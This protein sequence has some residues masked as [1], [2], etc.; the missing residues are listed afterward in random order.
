MAKYVIPTYYDGRPVDKIYTPELK[1]VPIMYQT[2]DSQLICSNCVN[3]N[4]ALCHD[5][6]SPE[7]YV[8]GHCQTDEATMC[9]ECERRSHDQQN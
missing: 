3:D 1:A 8:V 4:I 7:Y 5:R 2:E 9:F 6:N